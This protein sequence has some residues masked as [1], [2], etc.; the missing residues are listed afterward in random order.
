MIAVNFQII[1]Q[2][3]NLNKIVFLTLNFRS[4]KLRDY[5]N[6]NDETLDV[7]TRRD[8]LKNL[9]LSLRLKK[10]AIMKKHKDYSIIEGER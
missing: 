4:I 5:A 2:K 8:T 10:I 9:L 3:K 7:E 6:Y 1:T